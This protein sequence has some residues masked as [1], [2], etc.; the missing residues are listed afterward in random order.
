MPPKIL[1]KYVNLPECMVAY[2]VPNDDGF[3]LNQR[4]FRMHK[5]ESLHLNKIGNKIK[6]NWLKHT[7]R[8]KFEKYTIQ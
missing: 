2:W 3:K 1:Q 7:N 4:M 6:I 5:K 8:I